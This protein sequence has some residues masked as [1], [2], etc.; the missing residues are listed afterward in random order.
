MMALRQ[1]PNAYAF[2]LT[3]DGHAG[4][5][6]L[7]RP[8][9]VAIAFTV[10][11][12]LALGAYLYGMHV[13]LAP[14]PDIDSPVMTIGTVRLPPPTPTPQTP[15]HAIAV[16]QPA[17]VDITAPPPLLTHVDPPTTVVTDQPPALQAE[18]TIVRQAPKIIGNPN[19]L[20][21][22]DGAQLAAYYPRRALDREI[23]GSATLACMVTASGR[24]DD[25]HV[26]AESPAGAGFGEA[27]LKL[28]VFFQM[29]PR[30]IDGQPV[31]GGLVRIPIRFSLER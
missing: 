2:A 7:S 18:P 23:G 4:R 13:R 9:L 10:A 5:P 8:M 6:G 28:A 25:C 29:S 17:M 11:V 12:H 31:D 22:P 21:R 16:H 19:W 24:L 30:T 26:A 20:S 1:N 3:T 15:R 27:A 14:A